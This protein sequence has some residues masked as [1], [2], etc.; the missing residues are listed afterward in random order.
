[1]KHVEVIDIQP[2]PPTINRDRIVSWLIHS[3]AKRPF[4]FALEIHP[5]TVNKLLHAA[6]WMSHG[7]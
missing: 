6:G 1:M 3:K 4:H 7:A 2:Q 5:L